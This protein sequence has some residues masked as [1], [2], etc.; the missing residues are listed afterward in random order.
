[1]RRFVLS[2]IIILSGFSYGC[3]QKDI[4]PP[5]QIGQ[6]RPVQQRPDQ[7]RPD[8]QRLEVESGAVTDDTNVHYTGKYCMVCHEQT[9]RKGNKFLKYGDD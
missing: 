2:I 5:G 9:P 7:Q 6:R 3:Y 1:M 4:V 8:Q